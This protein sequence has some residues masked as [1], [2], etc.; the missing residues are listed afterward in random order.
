MIVVYYVAIPS[1][2]LL[3]ISDEIKHNHI[4]VT[5]SYKSELGIVKDVQTIHSEKYPVN[6]DKD[7]FKRIYQYTVLNLNSNN[8]DTILETVKKSTYF[9]EQLRPS[10]RA[11]DTIS[12]FK[13]NIAPS[14]NLIQ[15]EYN[16]MIDNNE[17]NPIKWFSIILLIFSLIV[18]IV[19]VRSVILK[20]HHD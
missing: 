8:S 3:L 1:I 9:F 15:K 12:Y 5:S 2:K 10:H 20:T 18:I 17:G 11:L 19:L 4:I 13:S 7:T 14:K 6:Y 16:E